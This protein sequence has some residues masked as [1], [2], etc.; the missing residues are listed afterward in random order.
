VKSAGIERAFFHCYTG[1]T[2]TAGQIM[3]AG[4]FIGVTGIVTFKD[5]ANA[6]M[7]RT[8]N[9][10]QLITET[11]APYLAPVPVRGKR[12]EPAYINLILKK[13][14]E[15]FPDYTQEDFSRMCLENAKALF[16]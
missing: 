7:I 8:L 10:K 9:P 14:S 11:D 16:T 4:Y 15:L 3:D 13:L 5:T 6:E 1:N 12:N 2:D